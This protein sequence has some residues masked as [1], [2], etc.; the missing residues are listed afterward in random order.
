MGGYL[1]TLFLRSVS[2][3]PFGAFFGLVLYSDANGLT[4]FASL[5]LGAFFL[6]GALGFFIAVILFLTAGGSDDRVGAAG[7]TLALSFLMLA[8]SVGGIL[9]VRFLAGYLGGN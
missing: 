5:V 8:I 1:L 4:R 2:F 3:D 7:R 9:M 6:I